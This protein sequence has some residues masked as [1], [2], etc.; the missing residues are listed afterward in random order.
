MHLLLDTKGLTVH[1]RKGCFFIE[2]ETTSRTISPLKVSSIAITSN[3][4]LS[5][6]AI[7]LAIENQIPVLFMNRTGQV[8]GRLW[9]PSF[10]GL[11][12]L[13]IRQAFFSVHPLAARWIRQLFLEKTERQLENLY[14]LKVRTP[15]TETL[16]TAIH[17]LENGE[18]K[19]QA[20][21]LDSLE[22]AKTALMAVEAQFAKAY[23]QALSASLPPNWHFEKRSRRPALD[24]FNSGL[25]YLY[26]MLYGTVESA[27]LTNGLDPN[28]GVLHAEEYQRP[29][30]AFD[31][32][33]PFRPWLDRRWLETCIDNRAET[34]FFEPKDEGFWLNKKGKAFI[35]PLYYAWLKEPIAMDGREKKRRTHIMQA[36]ATFAGL[37]QSL[38]LNGN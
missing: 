20:I 28:I 37:L 4:L 24:F 29:V 14:W 12:D 5:A 1:R 6:S 23:W 17:E 21:N 32:I 3:C 8:A 10:H 18:K 16:N 35:I 11:A 30:L 15:V 25:N 38:D 26:G 34:S 27:L 33:E 36:A 2:S 7:K 19:F 9:S 13:R 31:V 22:E